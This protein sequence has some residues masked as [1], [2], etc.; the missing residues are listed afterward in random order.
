MRRKIATELYRTLLLLGADD[1]LLETVGAW[2]DGLSD[3]GVFLNLQA[4]NSATAQEFEARTK[5]FESTYLI[6]A[7]NQGV[8]QESA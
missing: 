3:S 2:A 7:D 8:H 4:W 1:Q 5:H 6:L